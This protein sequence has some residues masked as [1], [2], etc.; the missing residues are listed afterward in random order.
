[1]KKIFTLI[2]ALML[3]ANVSKSQI[4]FWINL[5]SADC[6]NQQMMG[7]QYSRF[8]WLSN[9]NYTLA[10]TPNVYS[11][12]RYAEVAF[13]TLVDSYNNNGP[14]PYSGTQYPLV[15]VDSISAWV[16]QV[17]YSGMDDT[18]VYKI[19]GVDGN[20]YPSNTIYW[21]DTLI[22][23]ANSPL[24][25]GPGGI[26]NGYMLLEPVNF[27]LATNKFVI[28]L[29]YYGSKL[30]TFMYVIGCGSYNG[31]GN[32]TGWTLPDTSSYRHNT[33]EWFLGQGGYDAQY[34]TI[35]GQD[36]V[37]TSQNTYYS[38]DST[39]SY[40]QNAS[41]YVKVELTGSVNCNGLTASTN[42]TPAQCSNCADGWISCTYSGGTPP[43][44][45]S[46]NTI[47]VQT[48][49]NAMGLLPGTYTVSIIDSNN[50]TTSSTATVGNASICSANFLLY[51]DSIPHTWYIINQS[52]GVAPIH[53]DW[54]WGDS[55]PDDTIEFPSHTYA[56]TG[57]YNICLTIHDAV[58]CTTNYCNSYYLNR[59]DNTMVNVFVLGSTTGIKE[60]TNNSSVDIIPNPNNG[61]FVLSYHLS[62]QSVITNYEL[63][64]TDV[65]GRKVYTTN[66]PGGDGKQIINVSNLGNGVYFYQ[67]KNEKETLRGKFVVEK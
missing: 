17:N 60:I 39:T 31:F 32:C 18:V 23:P 54:N 43:Y 45:F 62:S 13:D 24:D 25:F 6:Y 19:L 21:S 56:D 64:V 53:Y 4:N 15:K 66:I 67:I 5:D 44:Q 58:G 1:M 52:Y 20:G 65:I 47:P 9:M 2:A 59:M 30:D 33:L 63:G 7:I 40:F 34:P 8:A 11:L 46:W 3:L 16:G 37:D 38:C 12:L 55:S 48:T 36:I 22:I 41:I 61:N 27:Q 14:F 10:D 28:R 29:E 50:C 51:P 26:Y 35:N 49:Q 42:P 57:Y